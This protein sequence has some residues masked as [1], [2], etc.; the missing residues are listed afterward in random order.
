MKA[1]LSI[2]P[3]PHQEAIDLIAGKPVITRE[4]GHDLPGMEAAA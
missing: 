1:D 2:T 4:R 3:V